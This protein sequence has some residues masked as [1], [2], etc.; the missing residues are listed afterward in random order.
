[1]RR[2]AYMMADALAGLTLLAALGTLLAVA[3][4]MRSKSATHL[5][6]QR[7]ANDA[8][9]EALLNLQSTGDA[10]VAD[11]S[12]DVHVERTGKRVGG[13]EW[14]EVKVTCA[15]RHASIAGLAPA[16]QPGVSP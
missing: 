12:A 1:M 14:V 9:Q 15:G 8:A 4:V 16:T 7:R 5:S 3:V 6:D 13:R 10:K 11:D 2:R